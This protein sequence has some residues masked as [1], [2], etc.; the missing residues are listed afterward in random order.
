MSSITQEEGRYSLSFTTGALLEREALIVIPT[1]LRLRDW[2]A[3]RTELA[4]K[5][6]LQ[7]RTRASS[8]RLGREIVQR[9]SVLSDDE[10]TL[11]SKASPSERQHLLW[12]AV[13]RKY[14]F[15][16]DF[17]EEVVRERYL[18]LTPTLSHEDFDRFVLGKALWH[19]EL[20]ETKPSTL[21]KLRATSFNMLREAGL[22]SD[23]QIVPA[24]ISQRVHDILETRSP[25]DIR[26][27]PA[28]SG[29]EG[30]R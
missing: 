23:G 6:A 2:G 14:R 30:S 13:C 5:N 11:L 29:S 4:Q 22:L 26:F 24:A 28:R 9:L 25:S 21:A 20:T 3:V 15:L 19:P 1:Y 18:L 7:T 12:V 10:L 27:F 16:G 8:V 17:A